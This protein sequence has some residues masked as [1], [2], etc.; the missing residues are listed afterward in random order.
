MLFASV[1]ELSAMV[2]MVCRELA[3]LAATMMTMNLR[4]FAIAVRAFAAVRALAVAMRPRESAIADRLP[5]AVIADRL[6]RF[7][8]YDELPACFS[9]L[10]FLRLVTYC[11]SFEIETL[12]LELLSL[13][14]R[15]QSTDVAVMLEV[16]VQVML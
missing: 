12:D 5:V 11:E 3:I 8:G 4:V 15:V 6:L 10:Y 14:V 9:Y 16:L 1:A 2:T 7:Q 13:A